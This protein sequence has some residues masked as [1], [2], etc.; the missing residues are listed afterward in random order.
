[1][2]VGPLLTA[3]WSFNRRVVFQSGA[4]KAFGVYK[5]LLRSTNLFCRGFVGAELPKNTG[6]SSKRAVFEDGLPK[7]A[8]LSS[9]RGVFEDGLPI[10]AQKV[11][12]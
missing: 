3:E 12:R 7:S 11:V 1:M 2:V 9:K 6:L 5:M 4:P 8:G 10:M